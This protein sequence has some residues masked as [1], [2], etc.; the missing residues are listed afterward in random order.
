MKEYISPFFIITIAI[1]KSNVIIIKEIIEGVIKIPLNESS[2]C[3]PNTN[4]FTDII[5]PIIQHMIEIFFYVLI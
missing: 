5:N 3:I 1:Q 4:P 2:S